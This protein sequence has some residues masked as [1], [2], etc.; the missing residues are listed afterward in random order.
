MKKWWM[1]LLLVPLISV[2]YWWSRPK[3]LS[4][5]LITLGRGDVIETVVNTKAGT[6]KSCNRSRLALP[7]GGVVTELLVTEGDRVKEGQR[8][9]SLWN[10]DLQAMVRQAEAS[11]SAAS[12][13]QQ[14]RCRQADFDARESV[15]QSR[16]LKQKLTSETAADTAATRAETSSLV[17]DAATADYQNA[18]SQLA[19][20]QAQL[21]K[22][23]LFAP[24]SGIVAEVNGER[25]EYMTPSPP[26]VATP[27]AIDLIDDRCVFVSAPI[28]EVDAARLLVGQQAHIMLDAYPDKKFSATLTRIAPYVLELEKQARTVEVEARFQKIP[29][30][31][32]LLIGYSADVEVVL[33][34]Q[35]G[36]VRLPLEALS[37]SGTVLRFED[38][39]L[40]EIEP[41]LG[42][43]NWNWAEVSNGLAEGDRLVRHPAR[44]D[45]RPGQRVITD[46]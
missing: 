15:R 32:N 42:L 23:T 14:S 26:G 44:L 31:L 40:Q 7:L 29:S 6:I 16:L 5:E 34:Q 43:R 20:A 13:M 33:N 11:L 24:F 8:L 45:W 41:Q 36:V 27:P 46:D 17:C 12:L 28:D 10:R 4:V 38:D 35:E 3:P 19:V 22:T 1:L 18:T 39:S 21:E 2:G 25:G 37:E 30:E 9:L